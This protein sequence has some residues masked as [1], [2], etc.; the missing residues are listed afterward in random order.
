MLLAIL[1][2]VLAAC[3][4]SV[5]GSGESVITPEYRTMAISGVDNP[6]TLAWL[7]PRVRE[8][9]RDELTRRG[10]VTWTDER[11]RADS[12]I[13]ITIIKYY[14]PT[15]VEGSSDQTLRSNAIFRFSAEIKSATDGHSIW[16]SGEI[17]Q[18]WPFYQGQEDEADAEVTSLGIRRLA[19]RMEQNY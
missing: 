8:L 4:Y 11:S 13:H 14:R 7:E 19:D 16:S 10:T 1:L 17:G 18:D 5:G 6:T 3:G 15:A 2:L 9:L 12:L